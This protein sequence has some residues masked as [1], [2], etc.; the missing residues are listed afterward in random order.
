MLSF[1][2]S[3]FFR[4]LESIDFTLYVLASAVGNERVFLFD[5]F[6]KSQYPIA[7]K[8]SN[9]MVISAYGYFMPAKIPY[10]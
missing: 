5:L 10:R 3:Q 4:L 8:V 1:A 6:H 2:P 7:K 9:L